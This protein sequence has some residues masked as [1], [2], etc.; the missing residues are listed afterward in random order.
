MKIAFVFIFI[1]IV[2][3]LNW[4]CGASGDATKTETDL[5]SLS[6]TPKEDTTPLFDTTESTTLVV[7]E[8]EKKNERSSS[9]EKT[10]QKKPVEV[11]TIKAKRVSME[12]ISEDFSTDYLMGKFDPNTHKDFTSIKSIHASSGGMKLRKDTYESFQQMYNAALKDGVRLT[13]ISATRP[14]AHQKRIWEAKW[15]GKRKVNGR[16]LPPMVRDE[17]KRAR[18]ILMYSSMPGTSRHHWGTDIDLNDLN[19]PYF[20][21]GKGKK[22]YDW[23]VANAH[24]YGFCQVYSEQGPER[25]Y[26]YF[27]EKWHWSYVPVARRLTEQYKLKIQNT[28]ITGFEGSHTAVAIDMVNN[29]VLGINAACK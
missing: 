11:Q 19:N 22:I 12:T 13:I 21:K 26:G 25:P 24:E 29:Y 20:E 18:L 28:D 27:E 8:E 14:F 3:L 9:V 23:L 10:A 4:N 2:A 15:F 7:E 16:M 6:E 1:G 17:E 5:P